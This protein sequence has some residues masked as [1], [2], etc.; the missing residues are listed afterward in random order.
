MLRDV[1]QLDQFIFTRTHHIVMDRLIS[2]E[3][4][5]SRAADQRLRGICHRKTQDVYSAIVLRYRSGAASEP[6]GQ[7]KGNAPSIPPS[8]L[9][10]ETVARSFL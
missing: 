3:Q 4:I 6:W 8:R 2:Y 9:P 7:D 10:V 1:E 5:S